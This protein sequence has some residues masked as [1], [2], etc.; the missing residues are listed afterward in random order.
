MLDAIAYQRVYQA[1]RTALGTL[2]AL[3]GVRLGRDATRKN[4]MTALLS[5]RRLRTNEE[6]VEETNGPSPCSRRR[7]GTVSVDSCLIPQHA[8]K[9]RPSRLLTFH[10]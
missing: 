7:I 6:V 9:L 2:W 4:Q 8:S 10:S 5:A 3:C 1:A